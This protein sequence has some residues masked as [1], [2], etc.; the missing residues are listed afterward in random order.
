MIIRPATEADA[1]AIGAMWLELVRYHQALDDAMPTPT[2]DGVRRYADRIRYTLNDFQ[3]QAYVA[4]DG[5]ELLGY[6]LGSVVDLLP[7]TFEEQYAGMVADIYVREAR[8]G[9]GIGASLMRVMKNWFRLRGVA[10]YEWYVAAEN[11]TGRAF[12][13]QKMGGRPIMLRMRAPIEID[14]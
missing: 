12:W 9:E 5:D 1:D 13:E 4:A 7:D 3:A 10:H 14:E 8:W 11:P 6:V 2:T